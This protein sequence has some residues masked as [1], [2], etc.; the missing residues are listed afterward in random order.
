MSERQA[1]DPL[2]PALDAA[3]VSAL[4]RPEPPAGFRA[5]LM[6]RVLRESHLDRDALRRELQAQHADELRRLRAAHSRLKRETLAIAAASGFAA[7]A[8]LV[9]LAPVVRDWTGWD[10]AWILPA[11]ATLSGFAIGAGLWLRIRP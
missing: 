3:L 7:G 5:Q 8:A 11:L 6:A 9:V 1:E 4:P 2:D 10:I